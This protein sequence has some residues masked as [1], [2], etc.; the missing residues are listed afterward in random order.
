MMK[1]VKSLFIAASIVAIVVGSIQIAG[2]MLD[3]G[4]P[5]TNRHQS[6]DAQPDTSDAEAAIRRA[7]PAAVSRRRQPARAAEAASSRRRHAEPT[8]CRSRNTPPPV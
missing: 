1:R 5:G 7:A 4:D 8:T 3:F 2:T 6:P